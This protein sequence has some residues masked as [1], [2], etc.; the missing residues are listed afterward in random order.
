MPPLWGISSHKS[1]PNDSTVAEDLAYGSMANDGTTTT[2]PPNVSQSDTQ[3]Q[4][5][6]LNPD[7]VRV[8]KKLER[9]SYW[10]DDCMRIP[11]TQ[12]RIGL[13][14][15]IGIMPF[16]GDFGSSVIS[17]AFV[18]KAAPVLSKYTVTRMLV[19]VWID[20]VT[21]VVPFVGDI[22]DIGWKANER[23]LLIFDDHMERGGQARRNTDRRW[24]IT[25]VI[26]FLVFCCLT[27]MMVIAFI[28]LLVL[29]L[30]GNL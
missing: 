19:N 21:G 14:P 10:M 7:E 20:A 27:T 6:T 13:D 22:F 24:V 4:P 3:V 9:I 25:I 8:R 28:I 12:R 23:N 26:V 17:L 1:N 15:I 29:Y 2:T 5:H 11:C 18:A 30:T 16:I